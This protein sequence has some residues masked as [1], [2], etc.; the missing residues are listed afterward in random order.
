MEIPE[1][2]REMAG[3]GHRHLGLLLLRGA[4]RTG[5][6]GGGGWFTR[7]EGD[8]YILFLVFFFLFFDGVLSNS[9]FK[10]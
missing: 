8:V 1:P 2:G 6:G 5:W 10:R 9:K 4:E 7:A 3:G